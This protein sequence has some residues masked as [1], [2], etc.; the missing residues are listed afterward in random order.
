[1]V[2]GARFCAHCGAPVVAPAAPPQPVATPWGQAPPPASV[3][4]QPP[5]PPSMQWQTPPSGSGV[6]LPPPQFAPYP[7]APPQRQT[8]AV[9]NAL[10]VWTQV[11]CWTL[12]GFFAIA[13]MVAA[14]LR[15]VMDQFYKGLDRPGSDLRNLAFQWTSTEGAAR[16]YFVFMVFACAITAILVIVWSYQ[17]TRAVNRHQPQGRKWTPGWAIGAWFIPV[18]NYVLPALVLGEDARIATAAARTNGDVSNW[19]HER[20][21]VV[22]IL[23]FSLWAVGAIVTAVGNSGLHETELAAM[24]SHA[25]VTFDLACLIIGSVISAVAA[26][27]AAL[28][29]RKIAHADHGK[30]RI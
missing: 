17:V 22:V 2:D 30:I 12:A 15:G 18:A 19:R 1:M 4:W 8:L 20:R 29:V 25:K 5:V 6:P 11:V 10:T 26:A 13:A 28:S 7:Y 21:T 9:S 3:G 24:P 27:F 23:W 14:N 16:G